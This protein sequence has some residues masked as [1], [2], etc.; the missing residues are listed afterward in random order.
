VLVFIWPLV[1]AWRALVGTAGFSIEEPVV[2]GYGLVLVMG[3]GN[4]LVLRY[5]PA[6]LL[7]MAG[8]LLVVLP[9]CPGTA[10]WSPA[11][12]SGW[13]LGMLSLATA[14]WVADRLAAW[15]RNEIATGRSPLNRIWRDFRE[16][17]GIVWA[18]RI[19]ERFNEDARQKDLPLR[20]GMQGLEWTEGV[21]PGVE[22]DR[23]SLASAEAS[24]RW[25]L[26]KFVDAEWIDRR[27]DSTRDQSG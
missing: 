19:Q 27:L 10:G 13:S 23:Q 15:E 8:L 4:Y 26:Q 2:F 6:A 25:L 11:A 5:T 12:G 24:L 1:P 7:W 18:R 17:F 22:A 14:A 3:A 20:L 9:L 16:L 21:P